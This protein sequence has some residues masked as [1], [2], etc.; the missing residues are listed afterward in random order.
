ML[1]KYF[2]DINNPID[3][4]NN[5]LIIQW[6]LTQSQGGPAAIYY[7]ITFPTRV[8]ASMGCFQTGGGD[9]PNSS[10]HIIVFDQQS[11]LNAL[12]YSTY[13]NGQKSGGSWFAWIAIGY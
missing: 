12:L 7:P 6:G 11:W 5:R 8:V 10:S 13:V 3:L 9:F 2:W 4:W 1:V